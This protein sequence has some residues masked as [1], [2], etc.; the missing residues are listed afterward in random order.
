MADYHTFTAAR[1][2]EPDFATLLANLKALD[3]SAGVQ[4]T[5]GTQTYV[6][7]KA[8]TWT[9]P[10]INA[11][12]NVLNTAPAASPQLTAQAI[13]D[14]M[15]IFEKAIILALIDQLN[16]IRSK[17]S[18]PLPDITTQQAIEAVRTKAGQL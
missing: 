6:L 4:H 1:T 11:A 8:T 16:V 7:K 18:P 17:L 2:T 13:I 12:Q 15:P 3:A 5:P 14:K 9:A 10:H